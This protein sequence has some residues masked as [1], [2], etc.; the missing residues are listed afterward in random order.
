MNT[1]AEM[2]RG[3]GLGMRWNLSPGWVPVV[4]AGVMAPAILLAAGKPMGGGFDDVVNGIEHK[5]HVHAHKIP[6]MGLIS[7]AAGRATHGGVRGLHV[8]EIEN[9]DA[10]VDGDELTALVEGK[11]GKGWSRMIR[12]TSRG[13]EGRRGE[14]TLIYV[15]EEGDHVGML[16]VALDGGAGKREM[17][18]VQLSMNPDRL[19]DEVGQYRKGGHHD[20]DE[21]GDK[22]E[23]DE[24]E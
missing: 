6:F 9:F 22:A 20:S 10:D 16:V 7:F 4:V 3:R 1:N 23:S 5:Y 17:N 13:V 21:K 19:M 15:R 14:Q 12:E 11:A 8:A 18:V 24:G 2:A